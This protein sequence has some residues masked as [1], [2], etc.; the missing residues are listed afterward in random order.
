M[1]NTTRISPGCRMFMPQTS[2][3]KV[4]SSLKLHIIA[5]DDCPVT[6][7]NIHSRKPGHLAEG[8][9]CPSA[10]LLPSLAIRLLSGVCIPFEIPSV[11]GFRLRGDN[12]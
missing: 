6:R 9:I 3:N 5:L 4:Y 1:I 11:L 12:N 2:E 10:I 7:Y 8:K